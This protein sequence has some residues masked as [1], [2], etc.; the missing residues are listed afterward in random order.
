VL[1]HKNQVTWDTPAEVRAAFEHDL[2]P[3]VAVE[4]A[5]YEALKKVHRIEPGIVSTPAS[6]TD[7]GG[8]DSDKGM[9]STGVVEVLAGG[10]FVDGE[11][12]LAVE[13][14]AHGSQENLLRSAQLAEAATKAKAMALAKLEASKESAVAAA[15]ATEMETRFE[16]PAIAER[17]VARHGAALCAIIMDCEASSDKCEEGLKAWKQVRSA[18][19]AENADCDVIRQAEQESQSRFILAAHL[20]V[21]VLDA[22]LHRLQERFLVKQALPVVNGACLV[23]LL[24]VSGLAVHARDSAECGAAAVLA[25]HVATLVR[26][27]CNPSRDT[28]V[29]A[30]KKRPKKGGGVNPRPVNHPVLS[31]PLVLKS[32]PDFH[33]SN[34]K[35]ILDYRVFVLTSWSPLGA[36]ACH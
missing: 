7:S 26:N 16:V 28:D 19:L 21:E 5:H 11:G 10:A 6:S 35:V 31:S 22:E 36:R 9:D 18:I 25:A 33:P 34:A 24:S 8:R 3:E 17:I 1:Q 2:L 15:A 32:S 20:V 29:G 13:A 23:G 12:A 14:P 4:E 30:K 27:Y